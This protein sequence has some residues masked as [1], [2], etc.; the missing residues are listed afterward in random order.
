M[1]ILF[2][3]PHYFFPDASRKY[4]SVRP[5]MKKDRLYGLLDTLTLLHANVGRKPGERDLLTQEA[6]PILRRECRQLQVLVATTRGRHLLRQLSSYQSYFTHIETDV[7]P[8]MLEFECQKILAD[9]VDQF[10][11]LCFLEDDLL[12]QDPFFMEKII[13]FNSSFGNPHCLLQPNRFEIAEK[14]DFQKFYIDSDVSDS[15]VKYQDITIDNEI[16]LPFLNN[17]VIFRRRHNP[18]AGAYFL[19]QE[20]FKIWMRQPYFYDKDCGLTGPLESAATLGIMKT[21]KIYKP[22][23]HSVE[24]LELQHYGSFFASRTD[25]E[26]V[27]RLLKQ[28]LK[29]YIA[30]LLPEK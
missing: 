4:A 7:E 26:N 16:K 19:S 18:H 5:D 8:M 23:E 2:V 22:V 24:F 20:Q 1:K 9:R 30:L 17:E 3:V 25:K 28:R 29:S 14:K 13:W 11:Y 12:I 10:D 27:R 15:S 6:H 21:F